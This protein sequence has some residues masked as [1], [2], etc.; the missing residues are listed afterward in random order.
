M[1]ASAYT[2][3]HSIMFAC[4]DSISKVSSRLCMASWIHTVYIFNN[5]ERAITLIYDGYDPFFRA[6]GGDC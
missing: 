4:S 2:T 6:S 3:H 1:T 5:M